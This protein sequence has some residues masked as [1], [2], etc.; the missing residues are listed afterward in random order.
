MISRRFRRSRA[1]VRW[2]FP[3][4]K[5]AVGWIVL[6][7]RA[8][9]AG[10]ALSRVAAAAQRSESLRVHPIDPDDSTDTISVVIPARN[11]ALRI[12]PLLAVVCIDPRVSEVIVV[13]DESTDDTAAIARRHGARVVPG[14]ALP[15][16][17]VGKPWALQQGL[18]AATGDWLVTFDADVVPA[19]GLVGE[20]V[21]RSGADGLDYASAGA[22]FVCDSPGQQ[23]LHPAML[24]TLVLRFGPAGSTRRAKAHR[25]IANGQCTVTRREAFA[26]VGGFELSKSNMTD[27]IALVRA[28]A[29]RGWATALWDGS[30]VCQVKMHESLDEVWRNWGRSLPMPDVTK[31]VDQATDLAV[32]WGAQALPWLRAMT[33]RIDA[34]DLIL[35]I[36]RVGTLAGTARAYQRAGWAY[37]L[38]PTADVPAVARLTWGALR[39]GRTWRGRTY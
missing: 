13:D 14:R 9:T 7:G 8:L 32:L 24:T 1:V 22:Q 38:S 21:R 36:S 26:R 29:A 2:L 20:L 15:P 27:D 3:I 5:T 16:G 39:P 23:W 17:W 12:E 31:P 28:L 18:D 34:I 11:E 33:G 35:G 4:P 19:P 25:T 30:D 10:V 37:W 6:G